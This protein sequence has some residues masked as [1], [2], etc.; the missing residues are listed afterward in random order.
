MGFRTRLSNTLFN[1]A[2]T[3]LVAWS[4]L[5]VLGVVGALPTHLG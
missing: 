2:L 4:G 3:L 5:A 1:R